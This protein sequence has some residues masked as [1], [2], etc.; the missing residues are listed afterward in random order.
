MSL[1]MVGTALRWN[2]FC[3]R[4]NWPKQRAIRQ[5]DMEAVYG[6]EDV[7]FVQSNCEARGE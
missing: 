5:E 1:A 7:C 3:L 2:P 4:R 6:R